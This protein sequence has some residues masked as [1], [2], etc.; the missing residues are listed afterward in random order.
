MS[1]IKAVIYEIAK[2]DIMVLIKGEVGIGR[3]LLARAIH[4]NSPR[5]DGPFFRIDC[6]LIR[7]RFLSNEFFGLEE[8]DLTE[9]YFQMLGNGNSPEAVV[10]FY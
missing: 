4:L 1:K 7:I 6:P 5:K 3:E 10:R 8:S 2:T 9:G